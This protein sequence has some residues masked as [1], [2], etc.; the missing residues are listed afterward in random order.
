MSRKIMIGLLVGGIVLSGCLPGGQ[1]LTKQTPIRIGW[2]TT[3]A[4]QGQIVQALKHTNILE[5][6]GLEGAF[7]GVTYGAPLNEAA[8]AGAVD[9]IFTA[10]QPAATLLARG[11]NWVIIARLMFNRVALYVPPESPIQAVADL[12]GATIAMPFGAAAQRIALKA[13]QDAGIDPVNG[14]NAVNLDITEQ[15]GI[16]QKGSRSSWG[17]IDAMAG[18]DPTPAVFETEGIA[19]ML[20]VGQVTSLVLMSRD[21]IAA[22]PDAP[23]AF[24]KAFEESYLYYATHQ[25]QCNDWFR[26]DSQITFGDNVLDLAASVEPNLQAKNISDVNIDLSPELIRGLQ[27]AA[28]F[29]FQAGLVKDRVNMAD[30]IDLGYLKKANEELRAEPYDAGR[31]QSKD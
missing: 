2:Q 30:H 31:I 18:F 6:N 16:V 13:I 1:G 4:T 21:Y 8:L 24:L 29:I 25:K 12:E 5:N 20:Y 7:V 3:W 11:G 10:D 26:Q 28:D 19:R 27:A 9:V 17:E 23:V 15:A 22:H 14:I